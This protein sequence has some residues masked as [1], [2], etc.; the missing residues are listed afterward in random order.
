[1][2]ELLRRAQTPISPALGS[3]GALCPHEPGPLQTP[4]EFSSCLSLLPKG[5]NS[6]P[7]RPLTEHQSAL[8]QG[9]FSL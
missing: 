4:G 5:H 9:I 7:Q 8:I 6:Q 1:M 2:S 3:V